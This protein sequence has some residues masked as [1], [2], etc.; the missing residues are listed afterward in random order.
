MV[1]LWEVRGR[2]GGVKYFKDV[3]LYK[4]SSEGSNPSSGANSAPRFLAF[5]QLNLRTTTCRQGQKS[6][7][8]SLRRRKKRRPRSQRRSSGSLQRRRQYVTVPGSLCTQLIHLQSLLEESNAQKKTANELFAK[9]SFR[10]AIE[11]YDKALSTCPNYLDYDVAVLKSN[12]SACH[13][14]LEDWKE[15]VKAATAALDGLDKLQGR[16]SKGKEG[17]EEGVKGVEEEA[18]EEIISEGATKA[19]DTSDKGKREA[20]IERIRCKALM[21]RA[22]ARSELGGWS[23]LQAAEEGNSAGG[24]CKPRL[25]RSRL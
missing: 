6:S 5:L 23:T 8:A 3:R 9:A 12:I 4:V 18:D 20:D 21:R 15:A 24:S 2:V 25:M 11:T 14:K 13:L 16:K 10:D 19:E 17:D 1:V 22:K 7:S